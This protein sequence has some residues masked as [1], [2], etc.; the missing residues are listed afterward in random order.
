MSTA[1]NMSEIGIRPPHYRLSASAHVGRVRLAVS[2]LE[3]SVAFYR[4]VIGLAVLR[5]EDRMVQLG[6][7]G[8]GRVLLELQ[9]MPG[10]S[11]IGRRTRLGLY[12]T[13]FLLPSREAL[14]SFI[15]HLAKLG[16][17]FGAGDH[18][19]SEA[20]YLTDPDGLQVEVYADR[21]RD[22][23]IF[24]GREIVSA[25]G[26]VHFETMPVVAEDSWQGA[27]AGTTVG[28]VHLYIGD[29]KAA[30]K[31]YVAGLGLDVVTWRYPGALFTSAGGYHHH[32]GLNVWAAGSPVAT[33]Q[34]ARLLFWEMV[35]PDAD[36]IDRAAASL[37]LGDFDE[38]KAENGARAFRDSWGIVVALVLE[39]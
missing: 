34:D 24:E 4:D 16:V 31:F 29:L 33:E 18:I 36:E 38:I 10:V 7:Q 22:Q 30:E 19:Y 15:R 23:W 3:R 20:L 11:A 12:H 2:E 5:E 35:L 25:T 1:Q 6:A 28:H 32:V 26:P 17:P 14:S 9:E 39:A 21:A 8:G 13:A 37:A 27:P